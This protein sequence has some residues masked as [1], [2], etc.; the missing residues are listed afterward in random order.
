[1]GVGATPANETEVR[2]G[3][4]RGTA[5]TALSAPI[6]RAAPTNKE[7]T[8]NTNNSTKTEGSSRGHPTKVATT[9]LVA[10]GEAVAVAVAVAV[11]AGAHRA[12]DIV[13]P[14]PQNPADNPILPWEFPIRVIHSPVGGRLQYFWRNWQVVGPEDWVLNVL[15]EGYTLHFSQR[16]QLSP[17]PIEFVEP[18]DPMVAGIKHTIIMEYLDKEAIEVAP[19]PLTP[20][21]YSFIF[22]CQKK[23]GKWRAIINLKPLNEHLVKYKFR[24]L[25]PKELTLTLQKGHWTTSVDLSDAYFH[26]PIDVES[27]KYLRFVHRGVVYQFRALPFGLSDSPYVFT[28]V[29][30]VVLQTAQSNGIQISG[31]LDDWLNR[32]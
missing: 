3:G 8:T 7:V 16:I 28:R 22:L 25:T 10:R 13:N 29:I 24:M 18:R 1:V 12:P 11:A 15:R 23:S 32:G 14:L 31:Y 26:I 30:K 17:V 6:T 2:V 4:G 21:F 19:T 20:G 5:L 27:R 9:T